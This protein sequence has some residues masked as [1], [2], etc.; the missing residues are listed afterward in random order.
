MS[1]SNFRV[2]AV[3]FC[4]TRRNEVRR[5]FSI[6]TILQAL[7]FPLSLASAA[8]NVHRRNVGDGDLNLRV[9][10]DIEWLGRGSRIDFLSILLN[11]QVNASFGSHRH[12]K[13]DIKSAPRSVEIS[14]ELTHG[15][16]NTRNRNR[17]RS[18]LR[19]QPCPFSG[20]DLQAGSESSVFIDCGLSIFYLLVSSMNIQRSLKQVA[21]M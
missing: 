13:A 14:G 17:N 11:P 1:L 18:A 10:F 3:E 9:G 16:E 4:N 6:P 7:G 5:R 2:Q 20:G 19:D 21:S 15:A 8:P 12:D